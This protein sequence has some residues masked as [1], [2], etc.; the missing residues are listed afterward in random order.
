[1]SEPGG[2]VEGVPVTALKRHAELSELVK[3]ARWRYYVLDQPTVSD[4]QFDEWFKEL[5]ALEEQYPSLQTPESPTQ[6]VGAPVSGD[7]AKVQHLNRMA[8]T[9]RSTPTTWPPGRRGPSVLPRAT[10]VPSCAS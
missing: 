5:L 10:P 6:Q 1:V 3:E 2:E 9:T 7:F 4:A 8:S